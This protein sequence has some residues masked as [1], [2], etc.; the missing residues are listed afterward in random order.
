M[1][2]TVETFRPPFTQYDGASIKRFIQNSFPIYTQ[3]RYPRCLN[4]VFD[5]LYYA[6]KTD[7]ALEVRLASLF[8]LLENLKHT[9]ANHTGH[10]FLKGYFRN[11]EATMASPG[12]HLS[13][14]TLLKSMFSAVGMD[15]DMS[16]IIRLRDEL[17]HSGLISIDAQA[18]FALVEEIQ[19][20]IREYVLRLLQ[21][22]GTYHCYSLGRSNTIL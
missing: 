6:G 15:P 3:L 13:F 19:D 20:I 22:T 8:I 9:Y 12:Q 1:I 21:F 11:L 10:P 14:E 18:K 2:G 4:I 17:I 16:Q 5:Y 7:L